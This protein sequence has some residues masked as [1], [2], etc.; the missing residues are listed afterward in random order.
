MAG[1]DFTS[2]C[3]YDYDYDY[4]NSFNNTTSFPVVGARRRRCYD[5]A[6]LHYWRPPRWATWN[7]N[8][9]NESNKNNNNNNN[10]NNNWRGQSLRI[11]AP[12]ESNQLKTEEKSLHESRF[13]LEDQQNIKEAPLLALLQ[14]CSVQQDPI[15]A[16][17][18]LFH[19]PPPP[20]PFNEAAMTCSE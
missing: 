12:I 8:N 18:M 17:P 6:A 15:S 3:C 14:Q 20:P 11:T 1:Y 4:R 9:Q 5:V 10:N 13:P 7:W 2:C 16:G 19:P